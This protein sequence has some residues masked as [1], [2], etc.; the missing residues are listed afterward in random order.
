TGEMTMRHLNK[1]TWLPLVTLLVVLL[2]AQGCAPKYSD[3]DAFVKTPRPIVTAT[4]YRVAPPDVLTFASKFVREINGNTQMIR[5]DGVV[6]LP[7]LGDI[8]VAGKTCADIGREIEGLANQYYAEAD[9]TVRVAQ[10]NSKK[11]F[12]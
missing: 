11:I 5:P 10:F 6:T 2:T 9:V 12:V 8:Y 1:L 7:L 4:E 3:Y